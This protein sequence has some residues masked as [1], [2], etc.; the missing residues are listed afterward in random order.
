VN[1][2]LGVRPGD[3]ADPGGG[4]DE[5]EGQVSRVREPGRVDAALKK[6]SR[7]VVVVQGRTESGGRVHGMRR[8]GKA[9]EHRV[10]GVGTPTV[11]KPL[12]AAATCT[13]DVRCRRSAGERIVGREGA[14]RGRGYR[15][16]SY[17][18]VRGVPRDG[19]AVQGL[20]EN[21]L[22][23]GRRLDDGDA[24]GSIWHTRGKPRAEGRCLSSC[25][26]G[27]ELSPAMGTLRPGERCLSGP[28]MAGGHG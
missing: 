26:G 3:I 20:W 16:W 10:M 25:Q 12:R 6:L 13:A 1:H 8:F 2:I 28:H 4:W 11:T 14:A 7:H 18:R 22:D 5:Q 15:C 23:P 27:R 21:R 19:L 24:Y 17:Q 9:T